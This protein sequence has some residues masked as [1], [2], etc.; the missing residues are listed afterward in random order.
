MI[1]LPFIGF[2]LAFAGWWFWCL[3]D[4][5]KSRFPN[6]NDKIVWILIII[7]TPFIGAIL[8]TFIGQKRKLLDQFDGQ[9]ELEDDFV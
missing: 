6:P 5:S 3:I 1:A 4:A 7:I 2:L 9:A 8:Y